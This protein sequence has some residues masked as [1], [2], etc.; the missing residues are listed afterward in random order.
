MPR[1]QYLKTE[2]LHLGWK[3]PL[4]SHKDGYFQV[5]FFPSSK[6]HEF[7]ENWVNYL[8]FQRVEPDPRYDHPYA[9]TNSFGRPETLK[10]AQKLHAAAVRRIGL[11]HRKEF[12]T[13]EHGHRHSYGYRLRLNGF[14]QI[15]IQKAMHHKNP[16]SC[17][18]YMQPTEGEIRRR[19]V[20]VEAET[21]L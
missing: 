14:S 5:N 12:G 9:F 6:A 1:T 15:E 10:N 4:L 13:S 19:M 2:R 21:M 17:L 16:F 3:N 18:V 7:L 8:K 20:D 11:V